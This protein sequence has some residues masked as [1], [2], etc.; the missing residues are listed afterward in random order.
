ML[1]FFAHASRADD[2]DSTDQARAEFVRGVDLAGKGLWGEA[3]AS[4]E[5]SSALRPHA[6]T[7]YNVATCERALGAYTRARATYTK[8]LAEEEARAGELPASYADEAKTRRTEIESLL[9]HANV[10]VEPA[11]ATI[12]IDG[13]PLLADGASFVAGVAPAGLATEAPATRFE[14]LLDPGAHVI[15]LAAKGFSTIVVN[16]TFAPASHGELTLSMA[17][18]P[19]T[20]RVSALQ[21]GAIVTLDGRD[22]GVVPIE[23]T[24][25]AGSH[26][27]TV[28][29][30]GFVPYRTSL[31]LLPGQ[32]VN[33]RA[34]LSRQPP[35]I[36]KRWWFWAGAGALA[37]TIVGVGVGVFFATRSPPPP[38][39]GG[40]GWAAPTH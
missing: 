15:T 18:L 33:L 8:A 34:P 35:S 28:D 17:R 7:T 20:L 36:T 2:A 24:R 11:G 9:A 3:L 27:L 30:K 19:A 14:L 38:D 39:G 23:T 31:V 12:A 25:P 6:L 29:A 40:L 5:R 10:T 32:E 37:A 4:F 21:E 13:R 26:S 1:F 22:I 16:R